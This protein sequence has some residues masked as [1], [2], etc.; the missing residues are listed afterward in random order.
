MINF[1]EVEILWKM[2]NRPLIDYNLI[3][4]ELS[5]KHERMAQAEFRAGQNK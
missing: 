3:K 4:V 5:H 1:V 2:E